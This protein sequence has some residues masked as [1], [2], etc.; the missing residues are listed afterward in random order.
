MQVLGDQAAL[1]RAVINLVQNA[2]AHGGRKGT[3][4]I[5]VEPSGAIS[6][7]DEGPG[8]AAEHHER[9]FE[10][11]HRL[12]AHNRGVG[13]GLNIVREI[14]QRHKGRIAVSSGPGKGA[15]FRMTFT[16]I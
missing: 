8:I 5:H 14:V 7:C 1:E 4:T 13:L 10:P 11:F 12:Q 15:C 6:V 9:I 2:I 3:I 16:V